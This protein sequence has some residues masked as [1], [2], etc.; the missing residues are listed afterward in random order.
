MSNTSISGHVNAYSPTAQNRPK[1]SRQ[2]TV[3]PYLNHLGYDEPFISHLLITDWHITLAKG[4][5]VLLRCLSCSSEKSVES[6][7]RAYRAG[8]Q[9]DHK[10]GCSHLKSSNFTTLPSYENYNDRLKSF[11]GNERYFHHISKESLAQAGFYYAEQQ[12]TRKDVVKCFCCHINIHQFEDGDTAWGEHRTHVESSE[13]F[14]DCKFID[15]SDKTK[16]HFNCESAVEQTIEIRQI[17]QLQGYDERDIDSAVGTLYPNGTEYWV[18]RDLIIAI[19]K[20]RAIKEAALRLK[21]DLRFNF[22]EQPEIGQNHPKQS[23]P[24]SNPATRENG[25][26]GEASEHAPLPP[27][28]RPHG[29]DVPYMQPQKKNQNQTVKPL[30]KLELKNIY[31]VS[32][33]DPFIQKPVTTLPQPQTPEPVIPA[34]ALNTAKQMG[35]QSEMIL[36]A[37]AKLHA[38]K[39]EITCNALITELQQPTTEPQLDINEVIESFN[40]LST[41]EGRPENVLSAVNG[42][43]ISG[44]VSSGNPGGRTVY[45]KTSDEKLVSKKSTPKAEVTAPAGEPQE[46]TKENECCICMEKEKCMVFTPCNHLST[47]DPCSK[48]LTG[49]P[50]PIC[51]VPIKHCIKI[52]RS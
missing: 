51:R 8:K 50:C 38:N 43:T 23:Q 31:D 21:P 45:S 24:Y 10:E 5:C 16:W 36:R 39:I 12:S 34:H 42:G 37:G 52:F 1:A 41:V 13:Y 46:I 35:F 29:Y 32:A 28:T 25:C 40:N 15:G 22:D 14:Q 6:L 3:E 48:E 18:P 2:A 19:K 20:K 33:K 47:C 4:N 27:F 17:L 26:T 7:Y 11:S 44:T 49:K 30:G 9:L